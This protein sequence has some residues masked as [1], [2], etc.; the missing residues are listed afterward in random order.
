MKPIVLKNML[1]KDLLDGVVEMLQIS[2]EIEHQE[3]YGRIMY[4]YTDW[5]QDTLSTIEN[6]IQ[7][8]VGK[9]LHRTGASCVTYDQKYGK[10][11]LPPHFDGDQTNYILDFQVSS[12]TDWH[13]G[14]DTELYPLSDNDGV[15]F[16]PNENAHWR[17]H[18]DFQEGEFVTMA[19]IRFQDPLDMKDYSHKALQ[20]SDP[21]FDDARAYR[22]SL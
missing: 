8:I 11:H 4:H 7:D 1:P 9:K 21:A 2:G 3:Q 19:F 22:D 5:D 18:K 16:E 6:A 20:M 15:L 13:I 10:P 17:V 12:N 14:L